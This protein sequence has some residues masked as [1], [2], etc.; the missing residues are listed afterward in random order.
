MNNENE[1]YNRDKYGHL[2]TSDGLIVI[3]SRRKKK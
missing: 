3:A 1:K 2:R